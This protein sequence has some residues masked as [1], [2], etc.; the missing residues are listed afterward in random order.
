MCT[1]SDMLK[2]E[3]REGYSL[4]WWTLTLSGT[5]IAANDTINLSKKLAIDRVSRLKKKK[6]EHKSLPFAEED[7]GPAKKA[8]RRITQQIRTQSFQ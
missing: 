6:K 2:C 3:T 4:Q 8:V 7:F 5:W 1:E